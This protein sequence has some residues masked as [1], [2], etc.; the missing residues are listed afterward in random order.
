MNDE[1]LNSLLGAWKVETELPSS[2]QREVWRQIEASKASGG[3]LESFLEWLSKPLPATGV[4]A[5]ALALGIVAGGMIDGD[6][7]V[8]RPEAY[9]D[10]IDPFAKLTSR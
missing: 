7:S 9:V 4:C 3:W 8:S 6:S 5:A 1:K 2:F 10:S